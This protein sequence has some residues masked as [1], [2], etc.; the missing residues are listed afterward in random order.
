M[1]ALVNILERDCLEK[2]SEIR[3]CALLNRLVRIRDPASDSLV[4][5][6]IE[7]VRTRVVPF[8]VQMVKLVVTSTRMA[9]KPLP[10]LDPLSSPTHPLPISGPANRQTSPTISSI[11][12]SLTRRPTFLSSQNLP[13]FHAVV[14][15]DRHGGTKILA[16]YRL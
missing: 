5:C 11:L 13:S 7:Y 4:L 9:N 1:S 3:H 12:N 6:K 8:L 2:G 16:H 14:L 15:Y 10:K